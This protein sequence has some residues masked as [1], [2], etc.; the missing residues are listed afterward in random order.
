MLVFFFTIPSIVAFGLTMRVFERPLRVLDYD[1]PWNAMWLVLITQT[2]VGY[3]DFF[4]NGSFGR[5]I[6]AMSAIWGGI[7]LSMTFVAI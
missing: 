5:V 3:G 2:T 7:I 4:P 1:S 6:I